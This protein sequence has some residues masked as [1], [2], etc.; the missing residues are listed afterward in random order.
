M[1]QSIVPER[2]SAAAPAEGVLDFSNKQEQEAGGEVN[3]SIVGLLLAERSCCLIYGLASLLLFKAEWQQK[4]QLTIV[5]PV[6]GHCI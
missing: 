1:T 4:C 5:L 6:G 2:H 3:V